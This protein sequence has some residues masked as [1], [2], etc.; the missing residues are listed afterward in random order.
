[1]SE[2]T[3]RRRSAPLRGRNPSTQ[4]RS[5][6]SPLTT[7]AP[8][9]DEGP[10]TV[11]T[12]SPAAAS[13]AASHAPGSEMPGVPASLTTATVAAA[14]DARRR[15]ARAGAASLCPCSESR[16][17]PPAARRDAQGRQQGP[18]AAGVLA[19]DQVGLGQHVPGPGRE[20]AQVPY[21]RRHEDQ[22]AAP[23]RAHGP[24]LDARRSLTGAHLELVADPDAPA[25]ER[26][27]LGLDDAAA[28][29]PPRP[30]A[31]A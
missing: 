1:M 3:R 10:G 14:R 8:I 22:L 17:S 19:A 21:R 28:T 13:W 20:V 30:P 7:S 25:L 11:V 6:G 23:L 9:T 16:R 12:V 2:A 29:A 26:A 31:R 27:G 24:P 5:V 15:R 4:K 18:G